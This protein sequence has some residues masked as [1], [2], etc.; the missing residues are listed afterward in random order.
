V[1]NVYSFY[2]VGTVLGTALPALSYSRWAIEAFYLSVISV[3]SRIYNIGISLTL[4]KYTLN[5]L[6]IALAMPFIIGF[7]LRHC[8]LFFIIRKGK[9]Q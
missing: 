8:S 2:F 6:D 4:W 1:I 7:V 9:M 5:D 3:Y